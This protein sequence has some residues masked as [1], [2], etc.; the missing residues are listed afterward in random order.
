MGRK[1]QHRFHGDASR[2]AAVAE[3]ISVTYGRS[4]HYIADV[5]GGQGMLSRILRKKYNYDCEV[6]DPR[7]WVLKGVPRRV[8]VF[9]VSCAAVA[10]VML[11]CEHFFASVSG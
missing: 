1:N 4:V 6:L 10:A 5:A 7:P 2:F 3:L 8:A 9:V 11:F